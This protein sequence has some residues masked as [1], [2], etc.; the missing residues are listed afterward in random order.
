M[1]LLNRFLKR[2]SPSTVATTGEPANSAQD[3]ERK[4]E[5][6]VAL[7]KEGLVDAALRSY[8]A[9]IL[10]A[11]NLAR[12]HFYR[13][14]LLLD[15]DEAARALSSYSKA[16]ELKP[17]SS[18][19]HYNMGN[20][21]LRLG[22]LQAGVA[23]YRRAI[24]LKPDFADAHLSLGVTLGRLGQAAE[25]V[26]SY[27]HAA[28]FKP[29]S[30]EVHYNIAIGLLEI[31]QLRE[32]VASFDTALALRPDYIDALHNRGIALHDL[33]QFGEAINSYRHALEI[34]AKVAAIHSNLG[35]ALKE[36]GQFDEAIASYERAL[37][38]DPALVQAHYNLG[39]TLQSQGQLD[40]A[41]ACYEQL[42]ELA[43]DH[44]DAH[45][46]L[47]AALRELGQYENALTRFRLAIEVQPGNSKGYVYLGV[48][49]AMAGRLVPAIK[50]Y[51][52]ALEIQPN[53]AD[54][55]L[56]L[57]IALKDVGKLDEALRSIRHT[58]SIQ[59]DYA[60]AHNNLLFINNYVA[61]QP[62]SR[63]LADAQ[64]FGDIVAQSAQPHTDWPNSPELHR[65]LRVGFVSGDLCGHPVGYFLEGVLAALRSQ[66]FDKLE[67][68][69]YPTRACDDETSK[70]LRACCRGWHSAV[71]ISDKALVK[72]IREDAIDILVDLSG[73]TAH[74]R[75]PVFAW[76][77]APIQLSWLGYFAT[78][79]VAAMDYFLA[80]LWT[81]P[82]SHESYFTEK[83]W[84]LPETRLCFTPPDAQLEVGALPRLTNGYI[85]FGSFNNLSKMNDAVVQ[86][87]SRVL[88]TVPD[89]RL[90][91]KYQQ[92]AEAS[93]QQNTYER[94]AA[95]GID[96]GRLIFEAYVPR[97]SY[98]AAYHRVDIALDP[99][100]FP[101]G[102]T[103][104]EALW[105]GVPVLTLE[106]DRFLSRQGVGLLMNAGLPDWIAAGADDYVVRAAAHANDVN[107]LTSLR[108]GLRQQ[109]LASPIFD[110]SRFA[111]HFEAALRGMWQK[112]CLD[113]QMSAIEPSPTDP[114]GVWAA[115]GRAVE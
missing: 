37:K 72:R 17:D 12:A 102:T 94:F 15:Q 25:A 97:A 30:A 23:A 55:H 87:W 113:Q 67:L 56:G 57:G 62:A 32:A 69:A 52:Q 85:T 93:V 74:N 109:V 104:V 115:E 59:P 61:D 95:H 78:T 20:A 43:N 46:N 33:G 48:T 18:A 14:N 65:V 79:G 66:A 34:D 1:G 70:R 81:L 44:F 53:N 63:L 41:I 40:R 50:S 6:G 100:P 13:G 2:V 21:H 24:A 96:A 64:C 47:G 45:I 28:N 58:L 11:P 110:S 68:F 90:F 89:S 54:A 101:G 111:G 107:R 105:M 9:A 103:T 88:H 82:A 60:L 10:L 16:L 99:F 76:K 22:D 5:E 112:W 77:P 36:L 71:G 83:I 8:D 75:L 4:L 19:T 39:V 51:Q 73:H 80:D 38:I 27:M 108:A 91:L 114:L 84:R 26:T 42:L 3:A 31:N 86:L 7:E 92:L 35:T 29:D 49:L 98:L 106:G